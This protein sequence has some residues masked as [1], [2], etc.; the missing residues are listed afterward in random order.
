MRI[1]R[2]QEKMYRSRHIVSVGSL[3]EVDLADNFMT[4]LW[5]NGKDFRIP[6]IEE[7]LNDYV[8]YLFQ[9]MEDV[10]PA[11]RYFGTPDDKRNNIF[12][13][14]PLPDKRMI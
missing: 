10:T 12:G 7:D 3:E 9:V 2:A 1:T 4:W 8:D 14:F 6:E 5:N 11:G 13:F